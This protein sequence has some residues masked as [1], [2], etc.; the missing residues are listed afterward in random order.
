[1]YDVGRDRQRILDLVEPGI[2]FTGADVLR[3]R[4]PIVYLI[5][6]GD[7]PVYV[8]M[9]RNGLQRP[10][11]RQHTAVR[12]F[13]ASDRLQIWPVATIE[14]ALEVERCLI[15]HLMP[16][17]NMAGLSDAV[18]LRLGIRVKSLRIHQTK[19]RPRVVT[20][21]TNRNPN[22]IPRAGFTAARRQEFRRK[23]QTRSRA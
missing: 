15:R 22:R 9:S 23:R 21:N 16:I 14:A 11:E 3:L 12:R 18:A 6:R 1:M 7:R 2:E 20:A 5:L 8:G 19:S 13:T 17:W 4:G 10:F